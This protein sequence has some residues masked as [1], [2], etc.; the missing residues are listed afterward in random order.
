M[1]TIKKMAIYLPWI[2]VLLMPRFVFAHGDEDHGNEVWRTDGTGPGTYMLSDVTPDS[3]SGIANSPA[4]LVNLNG[5]LY[6][7]ASTLQYGMS[8]WTS[9]GTSGGTVV[10]TPLAGDMRTMPGNLLTEHAR[11]HIR[12]QREKRG[13]KACAERG[14]WF[15]DTLFG[16]GHPRCV[17]RQEVV[18]RAIRREP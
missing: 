6:F 13:A 4:N 18:H 8:L 2:L 7:T 12:M 14:L 9:D 15:G 10:V 16:A 17:A 5:K 11:V 3:S 1:T